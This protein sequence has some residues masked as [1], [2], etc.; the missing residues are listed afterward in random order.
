MWSVSS[1]GVAICALVSAEQSFSG[2]PIRFANPVLVG[3]PQV[4]GVA[5]MVPVDL[6]ADGAVDIVGVGSNVLQIY[7]NRGGTLRRVHSLTLPPGAIPFDPQL[8]TA[9]VDS[10]GLVDVVAVMGGGIHYQLFRQQTDGT[11]LRED[12]GIP[13]EFYFPKV[14]LADVNADGLADLVTSDP[15]IVH[16]NQGAGEFAAIGEPV[17][18]TFTHFRVGQVSGTGHPDIVTS[19]SG[20]VLVHE[21]QG[22]GLLALSGTH[23]V[24]ILTR[25]DL[26]D[27]NA[28]GIDD[29]VQT[30]PVP[31]HHVRVSLGDGQ[32]G[33]ATS[34]LIDTGI[35]PER[36]TAG[37]LDND[38]WVDVIAALGDARTV[39]LSL[40][41]GDGT[42][43]PG[44]QL[45]VPLAGPG[46]AVPFIPDV[47][48]ADMDGDGRLDVMVATYN[49]GIA[50]F[51]NRTGVSPRFKDNPLQTV[52]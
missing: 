12:L 30:E 51:R 17:V 50:I 16:L 37:D 5:Q 43:V 10:N 14:A 31:L 36:T 34:D 24:P 3:E 35:R 22:T 32:G 39:L 44:P 23:S 15:L 52:R 2:F 19:A 4:L 42:F 28:D 45:A 26:A 47:D 21:N 6:D 1:L 13:A 41:G 48:V 7:R 11:F 49:Q 33:F 20:Q 27:F 40:G 18:E 9:D 38:G 8:A 29:L 46:A 25:T